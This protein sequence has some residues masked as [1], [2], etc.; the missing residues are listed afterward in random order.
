M[1]EYLKTFEIYLQTV[2]DHMQYPL[3]TLDIKQV[4]LGNFHFS[5]VTVEDFIRR[6]QWKN[7][8]N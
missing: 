6:L 7:E 4:L 8:T 5:D 3:H 1:S 2:L